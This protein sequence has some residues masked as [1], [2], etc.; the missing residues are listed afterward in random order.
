MSIGGS[1]YNSEAV[2]D[3][4][5]L[6]GALLYPNDAKSVLNA[7][8]TPFFKTEV[9]LDDL[10]KFKGNNNQ[11]LAYLR[12]YHGL[13]HN[14]EYYVQ[15]LRVKP[16]MAVIRKFISP[17]LLQT[18]YSKKLSL[19]IEE[20][21]DKEKAKTKF[22]VQKYQNNLNHLMNL[23]HQHFDSTNAT[24]YALYSW[25]GI[26]IK[27]NREE[28][29]PRSELMDTV[30]VVEIITV[31]KSKGLEYHTVILP[32]TEQ[33]FHYELDEVLFDDQKKKV[34]WYV[35]KG[36]LKNGFYNDLNN[37]EKR[38][39]VKEETRLLYVAM[40]RARERLVILQPIKPMDETWSMQL[41]IGL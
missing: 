22:V 35:K 19:I 6:L 8:A 5:S 7:L 37:T 27:T 20:P 15:Q 1:F 2:K 28:D 3:F 11:I 39:I 38:E 26:N 17:D 41:D 16:V 34:G 32:F 40:T 29:E 9:L 21:T 14:L 13:S 25:L 24:L 18:L 23:I 36:N 31:H 10:V 4:Y 12:E 30:D 33:P